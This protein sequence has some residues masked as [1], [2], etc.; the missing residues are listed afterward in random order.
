MN[1]DMAGGVSLDMIGVTVSY[2]GGAVLRDMSLAVKPGEFFGL[3]GP[4]GCGK[5][6]TLGVIAGFLD[7]DG[8]TVRLA[9]QDVTRLAPQKRGVGVVFQ[10]YALFPHMTVAQ[11]VGYGLTVK[12]KPADYDTRVADLLALVR[13]G[14]KAARYPREL[15]GGE[16]QRVAIARALAVEPQLLLLDEPLSNLDARLRVEMQVELKRIQRA[17]QVT[18]IFVTHDQEEALGICDRVG[19][20]NLGVLEQVGSPRAIYR[21][22]A[23]HFVARFVGRAT[24]LVGIGEAGSLRI[25][26]TLLPMLHAPAPGRP[27]TLYLRPEEVAVATTPGSG[28]TLPGQ[29]GT[30]LEVGPGLHYSIDT[31]VGPIEASVS[32]QVAERL[33][34]GTPVFVSW[35]ETAGTLLAEAPHG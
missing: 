6:T 25:G 31:A 32:S 8:G 17:A 24:R 2:G 29:V 20:M 23:T 30:V 4:S 35:S 19:I 14:D 22:P 5:S 16:Q 7:A 9:G 26:E 18:T 28:V 33:E 1:A 34:S 11:N 12:R 13:L 27:F 21:T 10:N 15:S 3:I